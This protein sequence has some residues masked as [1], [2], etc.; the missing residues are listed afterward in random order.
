MRRDRWR[1]HPLGDGLDVEAAAPDEES[2]PPP[3][4]F[5]F[6]R[7]IGFLA[8]LLKIDR[9]VRRPQVQQLMANGG[10]LLGSRFRGADRHLLVQL[11]G[12]DRQDCEIQGLGDL[13]GQG[14]FAAGRWPHQGDDEGLTGGTHQRTLPVDSKWRGAP[15]AEIAP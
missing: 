14:G 3:L 4:V 8:E 2:N 7:L 15:L 9:L 10:P 5:C 13:D 6:D 11:P 12:I 1:S